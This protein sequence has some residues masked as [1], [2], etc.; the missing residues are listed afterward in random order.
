MS[1]GAGQPA[2]EV[3]PN[4][5]QVGARGPV[6][7]VPVGPYQEMGCLTGAA[8]SEAPVGIT[9]DV[10]Q[11]AGLGSAGEAKPRPHPPM[12]AVPA[13]GP[14]ISPPMLRPG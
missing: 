8:E 3:V 2:G 14:M 7:D 11:R 1:S 4:A 10:V 6:G 13:P 5:G 9:D 12:L